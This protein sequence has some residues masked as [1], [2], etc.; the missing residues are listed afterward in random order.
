[1]TACGRYSLVGTSGTECAVYP[2][3]CKR[4]S[5]PR[6]GRQKVRQAIARMHGGMR[7]GTVRF[8]TITSP[9]AEIA[10]T[11]YAEFGRRWKRLHL[12][13]VR[14]FGP[15]EYLGVVEPQPGRGAAHIHVIYRGPYIPQR[16]LS[17]AAREA[18]FGPI[19]DIRRAPKGIASYIAK[20]LTKDLTAADGGRA[21]RYFRRVRW[22]RG[23]C[24]WERRTPER[25]WDRWWIADAVQAHAAIDARGRGFTVIECVV[26]DPHA[27]FHQGRLVRWV[28]GL[29]GFRPFVDR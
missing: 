18:G 8:F 1:M 21:P 20:Y 27:R 12:R 10:A 6:C 9:G 5:C 17:N 16:W 4:W 28:R 24:T 15:I 26:A 19:V 14:R 22:S 25:V 13:I 23:W 29:R 7:L 11:T 3:P 2:L